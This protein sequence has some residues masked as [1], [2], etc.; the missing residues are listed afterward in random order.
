MPGKADYDQEL[1]SDYS[2]NT[3]VYPSAARTLIDIPM[4]VY[5]TDVT[6]DLGPTYVVS[7][8]LTRDLPPT[9]RRFCSRADYPQFY[10]AEKPATMPAGSAL[11][12]SMT[13]L[14][15]GSAMRASEG[16]G[17]RSSWGTTRPAQVGWA[18]TASREPGAGRRWTGCSPGPLRAN[19][20]CSA[21]RHRATPTGPTKPLPE[22]QLAIPRWT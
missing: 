21:F 5:Y 3:L 20:S 14:H 4:I 13:T 22:W 6:V 2:N 18:P 12:Y 8:E 15:R 7:A 16:P 11:I 17:S 10:A 9:G 19:A 1:H